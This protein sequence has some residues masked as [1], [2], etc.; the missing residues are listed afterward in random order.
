M[1]I[2]FV[3]V[4]IAVS[5]SPDSAAFTPS[6]SKLLASSPFVILPSSSENTLQ[7]IFLCKGGTEDNQAKLLQSNLYNKKSYVRFQVLV[8]MTVLNRL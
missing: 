7:F 3:N 1:A 4:A 5:R 6:S 2:T 8:V